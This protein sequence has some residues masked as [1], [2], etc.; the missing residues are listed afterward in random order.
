MTAERGAAPAGWPDSVDRLV[1]TRHFAR[2]HARLTDFSR[3]NCERTLRKLLAH[4]GYSTLWIASLILPDGYCR[5]RVGHRDAV[6]FRFDESTAVLLDVAGFR[7]IARLNT[8]T[9]R[10]VRYRY[11]G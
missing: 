10:R 2:R 8:L 4:P 9:A 3:R 1:V 7:E 6:V 5:M 11:W